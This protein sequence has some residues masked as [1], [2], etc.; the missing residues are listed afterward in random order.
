MVSMNE[1]N[2]PFLGAFNA[3]HHTNWQIGKEKIINKVAFVNIGL[4]FATKL[5]IL[6][7][8]K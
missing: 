5:S 2:L 6:L 8:E 3:L 4:H 7:E 1:H